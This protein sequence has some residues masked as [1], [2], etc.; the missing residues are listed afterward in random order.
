ML[1]DV[2][3]QRNRHWLDKYSQQLEIDL[4]ETAIG[5][6]AG[7]LFALATGRCVNCT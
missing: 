1:W 6:E 5:Y 4:F 3:V 2:R 7:Q